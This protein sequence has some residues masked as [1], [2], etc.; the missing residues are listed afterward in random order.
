MVNETKL[1]RGIR[2]N[3]PGNIE[4]QNGVN[5]EGMAEDQ[6]SDPRFIV[7][8][9]AKYGIRAIAR[10]LIA[11]TKTKAANGT[12][13]DTIAEIFARYAPAIENN[14]RAYSTAVAAG[15]GVTPDTPM[16]ITDP[17]IMRDLIK[18]IIQHENGVQPYD[19]ATIDAGMLLAG[20]SLHASER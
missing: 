20:I 6:S 19:N 18:G 12:P 13:I 9:E 14:T 16:D 17:N 8:K 11:Y 2:N 4:R 15:V 10:V 5:W 7:F 1:P 3:N